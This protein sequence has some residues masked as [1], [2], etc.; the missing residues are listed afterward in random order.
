[1]HLVRLCFFLERGLTAEDAN[2]AML[3]VGKTRARM[4]RLRRPAS[5]G[6]ITVAEVLA[7][8]GEAAHAEAVR[9]W[10]ASAWHAW[11]E[12]HPTVR[13]WADAT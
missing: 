10:A 8:E 5:L 13:Q 9:Q 3:R 11:H 4:F 12:H 2:A 1:M 6:D 7:A